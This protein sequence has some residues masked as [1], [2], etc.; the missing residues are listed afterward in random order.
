M[1]LFLGTMT[2][3][4]LT[5][6]WHLL[7]LVS[8]ICYCSLILISVCVILS[9]RKTGFLALCKKSQTGKNNNNYLLFLPVIILEW[10]ASARQLTPRVFQAVA[11][12]QHL[13]AEV[14]SKATSVKCL[15]ADACYEL[16]SILKGGR[17]RKWKKE[18]ERQKDEESGRGQGWTRVREGPSSHAWEPLTF[19]FTYIESRDFPPL[20]ISSVPRR[21]LLCARCGFPGS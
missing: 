14:I 20:L 12:W 15:E 1:K 5:C 9:N 8:T 18:K 16:G 11:I 13:G 21:S 3:S 4:D 10:L 7:V 2:Y 19:C 17:I 6:L